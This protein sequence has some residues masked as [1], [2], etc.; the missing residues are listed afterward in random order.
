MRRIHVHCGQAGRVQ[1]VAPG[2]AN[3]LRALRHAVDLLDHEHGPTIDV[4]TG[5]LDDPEVFPPIAH[6]WTSHKLGWVKLRTGCHASTKVRHRSNPRR[7]NKALER[8]ARRLTH[9]GR[10][11]ARGPPRNAGSSGRFATGVMLRRTEVA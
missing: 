7:S 6:V 8:T 11:A 5:S 10:R 9:P 3:L 1:V 4:T 2:H